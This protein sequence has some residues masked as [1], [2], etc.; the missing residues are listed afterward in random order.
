MVSTVQKIGLFPIKIALKALAATDRLGSIPETVFM[1]VVALLSMLFLF[2]TSGNLTVS[3]LI[4]IPQ[5]I[6]ASLYSPAVQIQNSNVLGAAVKREFPY[7]ISQEEAPYITAKSALVKDVKSNK[8]LFELDSNEKYAPASTTKLMTALVA[9]D[10]FDSNEVV[11]I[12]A[13]CTTIEG[14]KAGFSEGQEI[15]FEEVLDALLVSSS[16][17]A[18]CALATTKESYTDF[19][20][21][22]NEKAGQLEMV[23]TVFTN[24][25]GLDG[26]NGE[27]HSTSQDLYKLAFEVTKVD[28]LKE[29]VQ[30]KEV[31]A[32]G[33]LLYNTNKLLWEIP[34]TVGIKTGTTAEAGE[35]LIYEYKDSDKDLIIIV[36]GSRDRFVDTRALLYWA[37]KAFTWK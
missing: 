19:I 31:Q 21:R 16:A 11:G 24:P 10:L 22:M 34:Q 14:S 26:V 23:N 20:S 30:V 25:I 1:A 13:I 29:I 27:H 35:V 32:G 18:A 2:S 5:G 28:K 8:T 15:P 37:Q 9:L 3:S 6:S 7:K 17:D 36:M 12:P 4:Y 33:K